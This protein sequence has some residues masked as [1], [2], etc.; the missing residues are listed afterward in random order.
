MSLVQL[1]EAYLLADQ[2]EAPARAPTAPWGSP[3]S[4]ANAVMRPGPFAC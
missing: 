1:G 3:A 4:A 2:V